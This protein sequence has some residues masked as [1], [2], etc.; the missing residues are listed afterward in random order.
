[1]AYA[2][3]ADLRAYLRIPPTDQG[4]DDARAASILGAVSGEIDHV[5]SRTFTTPAFGPPEDRETYFALPYWH[6]RMREW[7]IDVPDLSTGSFEVF[8][9]AG[10]DWTMPIDFSAAPYPFRPM[11]GAPTPKPWTALALAGTTWPSAGY[12]GPGGSYGTPRDMLMVR[13]FFGWMTTPDRVVQATLIQS[14]R[15]FRRRDAIFGIISSP[16][17]SSQ[18][19]LKQAMDSDVLVLL[20]GLI[21]YWAAR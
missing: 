8:A 15:L 4:F 5:C 16:D 6:K 3:P 10:S 11:N 20:D 21:R 17:G 1:M 12:A 14:A 19:R 9:Y 18:S 7:R 13:A 2:E